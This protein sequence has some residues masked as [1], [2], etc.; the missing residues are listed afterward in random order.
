MLSRRSLLIGIAATLSSVGFTSAGELAA[1]AAKTYTVAKKTDIPLKG[2]KL[3]NVGGKSVFI[4]QPQSG[5]FRAFN[6]M[7]THAGGTVNK[8]VGTSMVCASHGAKFDVS[9][10]KP[11]GGPAPSALAK[12]TLTISGNNLKVT[13]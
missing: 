3:F 5:V 2:G 1:F 6:S 13:I 9:S 11:V 12:V 10:G 4:T 7:C 8:V